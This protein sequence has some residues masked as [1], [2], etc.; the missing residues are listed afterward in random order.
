MDFLT[1]YPYPKLWHFGDPPSI[2]VR[3]HCPPSRSPHL[4]RYAKKFC[5]MSWNCAQD[6]A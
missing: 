4:W 5:E 3:P 6:K 2:L 1:S